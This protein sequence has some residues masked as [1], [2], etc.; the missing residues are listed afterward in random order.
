MDAKEY[1]EEFKR[2]NLNTIER[3]NNSEPTFLTEANKTGYICPFCG[4]GSGDS[5]TG[6]AKDP[7]NKKAPHYTCYVCKANGDSGYYDVIDLFGGEFNITRYTDKVKEAAKYFNFDIQLPRTGRALQWDDYIQE[8]RTELKAPASPLKEKQGESIGGADKKPTETKIEALDPANVLDYSEFYRTCRA[9][10]TN[11]PKGLEY[12][13]SRGISESTAL[14][15]YIGYCDNWRSPEAQRKGFRPPASPRLI[16]PVSKNHYVARDIRPELTEEQKKYAKQNETG[17]GEQGIFLLK[18]LY[19]LDT[20][21]AFVVEG[22]IDALSIIEIGYNAI[23]LNS[24]ANV[25]LLLKTLKEKPT[26]AHLIICL[27]KDKAGATAT[28]TLRKGLQQLN[29]SYSVADICN[30][31]KD[32]NEALTADREGFIGAVGRAINGADARAE[33]T[34]DYIDNFMSLDI[35]EFSKT[36]GRKTGFIYLDK[37]IGG[38]YAGLYL[39]AG[40]TSLG[41]TTLALQLA[42]QLA[43]AGQEVIYFSLE[44]SKLELVT[45]S[46]ARISF[47]VDPTQ[48]F[49]SMAV[50]NG[51]TPTLLGQTIA[52]YKRKV[53][54]RVSIIEGNFN[55]SPSFIGDYVRNFVRR[56]EKSPIVFIDY[57][58]VIQPDPDENGR[59]PDTRIAMKNA[60][61]AF[62]RLSRE[63]NITV[64]LISSISRANYYTPIGSDSIK[65]AGD[66][67]FT[68]DVI[69]GLQPAVFNLDVFD[70]KEGKVKEKRNVLRQA[71]R[72]T[73]RKIELVCLKNRYG[74]NN[75]KS[76]FEYTPQYDLYQ[77]RLL[78]FQNL[79]EKKP[80]TGAKT[81]KNW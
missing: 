18:E 72:E 76:Y 8:D 62:K 39:I 79:E 16:I 24:T 71:M 53:G 43:E 38:L 15:C 10:L 11:N 9:E 32:P 57:M 26:K 7:H 81:K 17:Q 55:C 46:L 66:V 33:N 70:N 63:L 60:A 21:L 49:T 48:A 73:P 50:R 56:T 51:Y 69:W 5:G 42:D 59:T 31:H 19:K 61:L 1:T 13:A 75:F 22:A 45:K 35:A 37:T 74:I 29:I 41:K 4:N 27:D 28:E 6:I 58:Q 47:Q 3:I 80:Q 23:A 14:V 77:N 12:L 25:N 67:E 68:C 52:E 36:A 78:E 40:G 34:S 30:G 64:V 54:N 20:E 2:I 44:Q 65:E